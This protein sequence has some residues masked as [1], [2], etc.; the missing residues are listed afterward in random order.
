MKGGCRENIM[1]KNM[2]NKK[3]G[4]KIIVNFGEH[5]TYLSRIPAIDNYRTHNIISRITYNLARG[6]SFSDT[7]LY[8]SQKSNCEIVLPDDK[9]RK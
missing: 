8:T 6:I 5:D 4:E 9:I 2:M 7:N 1:K 3:Q